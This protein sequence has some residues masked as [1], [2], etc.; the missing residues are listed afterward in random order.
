MYALV[1][2]FA[3]ATPTGYTLHDYSSLAVYASRQECVNSMAPMTA[4]L[5]KYKVPTKARL[6]RVTR[7][8]CVGG[9][10][11]PELLV[12]STVTTA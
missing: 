3:L 4:S 2:V 1:M 8:V 6:A 7:V 9:E 11:V 10:K 5:Q 12:P